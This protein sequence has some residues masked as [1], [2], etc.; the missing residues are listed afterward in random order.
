MDLIIT[1]DSSTVPDAFSFCSS[2][3]SC[4][5]QDLAFV[6]GNGFNNTYLWD[7]GDGTIDSG[8][9]VGHSF[10]DTGNYNVLLE[11]IN[12]CNNPDTNLLLIS[13]T[14]TISP[15][16]WLYID[17]FSACPGE[18]INF[19]G[20]TNAN[21]YQLDFGD[22]NYSTSSSTSHSYNDTGVYIIQLS[23]GNECGNT[24]I[25]NDTIEI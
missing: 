14:D 5:E 2:Y 15:Y 13:I 9:T 18:T 17:K 23:I 22:G 7:F 11:V 16:P 1:V 25:L 3:I 4:P 21:F 24:S 10:S 19:S 20:N 8:K 12:L 6:G